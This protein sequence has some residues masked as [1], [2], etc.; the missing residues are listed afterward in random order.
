MGRL[1]CKR[2]LW[3]IPNNTSFTWKECKNKLNKE[4]I[5][6]SSN[7]NIMENYLILYIVAFVVFVI[8]LHSYFKIQRNEGNY[9]F[10]KQYSSDSFKNFFGERLYKILNV[11]YIIILG[12]STIEGLVRFYLGIDK[13]INFIQ[14]V[15]PP[16]AFMVISILLRVIYLG[17]IR[18]YKYIRN[19]LE[20]IKEWVITIVLG[21]VSIPAII[22]FLYLFL[23]KGCSS[24]GYNN[25]DH[26]HYERFHR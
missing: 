2:R 8:L 14:M 25:T 22:F 5:L 11:S 12:I 9:I 19:N 13:S 24:E 20:N 17:I 26:I 3:I 1:L 16:V 18:S 15:I 23:F 21:I 10:S 7:Y 4:L 6:N